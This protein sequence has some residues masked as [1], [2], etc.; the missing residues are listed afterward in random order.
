MSAGESYVELAPLPGLVDHLRTVWVQTTGAAPYLQRHLPTGGAELHW[1]LGG[2]PRLLG[3]LTGPRVEVIPAS[4]ILLG[5]RF[6]PGAPVLIPGGVGDLLD[7]QVALDEVGHRWVDRLGEAIATAVTPRAGL[8]VL[9]EFLLR[10]TRTA[11][12]DPLVRA[13]VR[14]LMPWAPREIGVVADHL[15]LSV[16][17]FRRRCVWAVGTGPK[18]LQRTLRFQGFLAL[19]QSGTMAAGRRGADG[20]VGLA[21]D[22]GY[23]DQAHLSREVRRL[24]GLTPAGLL[25]AQVDRCS[26]GHDHT[27]SYAPFLAARSP[28]KV[29][30]GGDADHVTVRDSFKT[31]KRVAR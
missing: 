7:R 1:P 10:R 18:S 24:S 21:V 28:E 13:A 27:A 26:C 22:A 16:S 9:Q 20:M 30:V 25:G 8:L 23:A 29:Q 15:G 3:P 31:G 5:V 14:M 6:H 2:E 4:T 17:Q 11:G 12:G 19:A